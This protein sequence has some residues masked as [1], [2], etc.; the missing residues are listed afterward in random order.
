[1]AKLYITEFRG[2]QRDGANGSQSALPIGHL[3]SLAAQTVTIGAT[4]AQSSALNAATTFV[5]IHTDAACH[6]LA[7][8]NPTAT[9]SNLRMPADSTEYF[10]VTAGQKIAAITA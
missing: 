4:S 9:T 1:M 6:I 3:P 2:L 10:A 8:D 5:R 7:G